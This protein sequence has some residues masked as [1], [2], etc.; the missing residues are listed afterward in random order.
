MTKQELLTRFSRH[1][2]EFP[3]G[4]LASA[5]PGGFP[6]LR[7]MTAHL[8]PGKSGSLCSL[9]AKTF[10]KTAGLTAHPLVSWLFTDPQ[11]TEIFSLRG[12]VA[13]NENP[14][15][16]AEL[17]E[18]LGK[19]LEYFWRLNGDPSDL[20]C[21]ETVLISGEYFRPAEGLKERWEY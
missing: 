4:I 1:L 3:A 2:E 20:I 21:L 11:R 7:F 9:T 8:T 6:S 19:N 17:L 16:K 10:P 15:F 18:S 13:V 12:Q 14:R 5:E